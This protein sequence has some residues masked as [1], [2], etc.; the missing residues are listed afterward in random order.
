MYPSK[1]LLPLITFTKIRKSSHTSCY[2]IIILT[3]FLNMKILLALHL[4][5]KAFLASSSADGTCKLWDCSRSGDGMEV[6]GPDSAMDVE[7]SGYGEG[8]DSKGGEQV[9]KR[10]IKM[11]GGKAGGSAVGVGGSTKLVHTFAGHQGPVNDCSFHPS[12]RYVGTA[13]NDYTW[14]LWD[15]ET[16]KELLLQDGHIKE[17]TAISFQPDGSLVLTA[18]AA[19]VALLWD[20]RSGQQVQVFQGHVKKITSIA[21]NP[22][23]FQA[24]SGSLDNMVRIWDLRKRKCSYCLPAHSNLISDL[25][26]SKSGEMLLTSS[27]DGTIKVWGYRDHQLLRSLSGHLGK[28]MSCD[29]SPLDEKHIVSGGFDRTIKLWAHKEEF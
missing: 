28:V 10:E 5:G 24:A 6:Q 20:L 3:N 9:I 17:C 15:V 4:G 7:G 29:F 25:C 21:F 19:G 18:D 8:S 23:G 26:Y 22:N 12:G 14:R 11:E 27:F 13:S 1:H 2:F 16:G